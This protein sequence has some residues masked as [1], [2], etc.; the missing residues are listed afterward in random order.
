SAGSLS[1]GLI[2][3]GPA[4]IPALA[5][6]T[7]APFLSIAS[8]SFCRLS[9]S[10]FLVEA[11]TR[12]SLT[13]CAIL[14]FISV[15][16]VSAL[17]GALFPIAGIFMD[18][19]RKL[20][21]GS[22]YWIEGAGM[23]AGFLATTFIL[24]PYS[25]AFSS[26]I[27]VSS[28]S[29]IPLCLLPVKFK[30]LKTIIFSISIIGVISVSTGLPAKLDSA[31]SSRRFHSF[32]TGF[33]LKAS[34]DTKYAHY[35]LAE[36]MNEYALFING[37]LASSFPDPFPNSRLA[38]LFLCEAGK[39]ARVLLIGS[40]SIDLA[41][42]LIEQGAI[43]VDYLETD[44]ELIRFL[45]EHAGQAI[46]FG[47]GRLNVING[48]GR[49]FIARGNASSYD[50]IITDVQA[51]S[52]IS[53]NRYFTREF[54]LETAR[55]LADDGVF[56]TGTN[57]WSDWMSGPSRLLAGGIF[58][59]LKNTFKESI[60]VFGDRLWFLSAK[61]P[62][63][64][65]D[66]PEIL[67]KRF[68]SLN[69][70]GGNLKGEMLEMFFPEGRAGEI[71]EKM[72]VEPGKGLNTDAHPISYFYN[73][74]L[75]DWTSG[76]GF[77]QWLPSLL[78]LNPIW[79]IIAS[80]TICLLIFLLSILQGRFASL[81]VLTALATAGF[82]GISIEIMCLM[83]FQNNVGT[84]YSKLGIF[85]FCYMSGMS[86][87]AALGLKI[88][89]I[90][91]GRLIFSMF[92]LSLFTFFIPY[93]LNSTANYGVASLVFPLL[94]AA[95]GVF[96]GLVFPLGAMIL[97]GRYGRPSSVASVANTADCIGAALG[98][99]STAVVLIPV[100]GLAITSVIISAFCGIAGITLLG[101]VF[102]R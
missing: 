46:G 68:H 76:N 74:I 13:Q 5:L 4:F 71:S 48:D 72:L 10:M 80:A 82:A 34:T 89:K 57:A 8:I 79:I 65:T 51:P 36:S 62:G 100:F 20:P 17:S 83:A 32:G 63:T 70:S 22:A 25:D 77:S 11:G 14:A 35:D 30:I 50:L 49:S 92:F 33:S 3:S 73:L 86:I 87:G 66:N 15:F 58:K 56:V 12:L 91:P 47:D 81:P 38:G 18:N 78:E 69:I 2:K 55:I 85:L 40:S 95:G 1:A 75:W 53:N 45:K 61:N 23:A 96:A 31:M 26:V 29:L 94:A 84:L 6:T 102:R 41:I 39:P 93:I 28:L 88:V 37:Q 9:A 67:K 44:P 52:T 7:A 54:F 60:P 64:I 16:P 42:N 59:A 99:S 90:G 24:I 101:L 19:G 21:A 27:L 98:A 43:K 97:K